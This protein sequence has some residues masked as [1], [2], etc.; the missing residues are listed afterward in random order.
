MLAQITINSY[1]I[2]TKDNREDNKHRMPLHVRETLSDTIPLQKC[3]KGG[4][5]DG[6]K[7]A[8]TLAARFV[9]HFQLG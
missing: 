6:L 3:Q 4:K 1:C 8:Q 9:F 7:K 5:R 2:C